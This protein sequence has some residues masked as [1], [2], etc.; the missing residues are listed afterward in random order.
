MKPQLHYYK[1]HPKKWSKRK[2]AA[3]I[4]TLSIALWAAI[5]FFVMY[6]FLGD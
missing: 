2:A 1:T 3:F 5:V 4:G 6:A